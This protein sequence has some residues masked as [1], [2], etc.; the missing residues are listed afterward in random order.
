MRFVFVCANFDIEPCVFCKDYRSESCWLKFWQK[1]IHNYS[2]INC[3]LQFNKTNYF[4]Y[5][6]KAVELYYPE[7][8]NKVS[9]LLILL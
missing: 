4:I 5:M 6:L 7:V 3:I 1:E 8:Y 2:D 9:K